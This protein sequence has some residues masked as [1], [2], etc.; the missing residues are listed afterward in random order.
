MM[1]RFTRSISNTMHEPSVLGLVSEAKVSVRV[2]SGTQ[3]FKAYVINQE[4][5]FFGYYPIR[6]NKV[7]TQDHRKEL[8]PG[9]EVA[10]SRKHSEPPEQSCSTSTGPSATCSRGTPHP[11]SRATLGDG[12]QAGGPAYPGCRGRSRSGPLLGRKVAIFS[13]NSTACVR[14]FLMLH[15]LRHLVDTVVGRT[16]YWPDLMKPDPHSMLMAAG[17]LNTHPYDCT[18]IGDSVTD[19]EAAKATGGRCI[20]FANKPGKERALGDAGADVVV[21]S[22]V[23]VAE[24]VS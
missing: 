11:K 3:F 7:V 21:T 5:A 8:R 6:P 1:V 10:P 13:N 17:Q 2:H 15:G 4:D 19:E 12:R 16:P 20:G 18:L 22:M 23:T 9:W 14:A 24:A